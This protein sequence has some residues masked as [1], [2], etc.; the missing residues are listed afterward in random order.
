[1]DTLAEVVRVADRGLTHTTRSKFSTKAHKLTM[2]WTTAVHGTRLVTPVFD[3][4]LTVDI[5]YHFTPLTS[6]ENALRPVTS[7]TWVRVRVSSMVLKKHT[8]IMSRH[9]NDPCAYLERGRKDLT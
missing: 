9:P 3:T 5:S 1:M 2:Q 8:I 6:S 7:Y 4:E